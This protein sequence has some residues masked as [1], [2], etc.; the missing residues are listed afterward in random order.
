MKSVLRVKKESSVSIAPNGES[1][2]L[3]KPEDYAKE[4]Q[5]LKKLVAAHRKEGREI[6][7]VMGL[8]FVGAVMAGI[9][10]DAEQKPVT[11]SLACPEPVEGKGDKMSPF[12]HEPPPALRATSA[13]GGQKESSP[14][15]EGVGGGSSSSLSSPT[16]MSPAGG[17]AGG[18]HSS[19]VA[20][21]SS[22]VTLFP[23]ARVPRWRGCRGW[24][25][26]ARCSSLI[27]LV[28]LA[29]GGYAHQIRHRCSAAV[30]PLLL[31][32]SLFKSRYCPC[33]SGR[34]RSGS[35]YCPL[36]QRKKDPHSHLH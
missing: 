2:P 23:N 7:V 5:R 33:R 34:P 35:P 16:L 36:C 17:G 3:P 8:G 32:N 21:C 18:G 31:E 24:S 19:L 25:L 20:R 30:H 4:F 11:P 13:S 26:A 9:V 14:P 28:P 22:L 6:V 27:A 15:L 29:C 10:A 12:I 1:F